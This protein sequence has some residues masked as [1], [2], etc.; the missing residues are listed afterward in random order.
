[1]NL[2]NPIR[3]LPRL[4]LS[5]Y[6]LACTCW[7]GLAQPPSKA[8]PELPA[9]RRLRDEECL[10]YSTADMDAVL[11]QLKAEREALEADWKATTKARKASA[12]ANEKT[13]ADLEARLKDV[14]DRL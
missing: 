10:R 3:R 2:L 13:P 9:P 4:A 1:M 5:L 11:I 6:V 7:L 14:L 8:P 12:T